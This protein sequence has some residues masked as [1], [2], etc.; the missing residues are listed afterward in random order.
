M[1]TVKRTRL[2]RTTSQPGTLIADQSVDLYARVPG[3]LSRIAVDI[4]SHV[5]RGDVLAELYD[6]ELDTL[7]EKARAEV[8]RARAHVEQAKAAVL[9]AQATTSLEQAKVEAA[10]AAAKDTEARAQSQ[11]KRLDRVRELNKA[12]AVEERVADA[13]ADEHA[14]S[15]TSSI[16]A[17]SELQ[18][19]RAAE[20]ET[21]AKN[22]MAKAD[23]LAAR[24]EL[25]V[26]EAGIRNADVIASYRKIESPFGGVVTR[27]NY[28]LG[29]WVRSPNLGAAQP[30]VTIVQTKTMRLV[31][32]VPERDVPYLDEGDA[33]KVWFDAVGA[34][35][36]Y[37]GK[38]SRTA[39]ALD[40][41]D[42]QSPRRDRSVQR[43]RPPAARIDGE[44]HDQPGDQ[45]KC[46]HDPEL[47]AR[48][49]KSGR[50]GGLLR[51][52]GRACSPSPNQGRQGQ[53]RTCRGSRR[54]DGW[55]VL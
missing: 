41:R 54:A 4:G 19:A 7:T 32:N 46:S 12:G 14:A 24:S 15:T 39:Y 36:L 18:V 6:P 30:I 21:Q 49:E 47:R 5:H 28:H 11:K 23:V 10:S 34:G 13:I 29:E 3:H 27:R 33:V 35:T 52:R 17:R 44:G 53:R 25:R 22:E 26:A 48:R 20:L 8:D 55:G 38:I 16:A 50:R 2:E 9:V 51:R 1:A 40:P 37:E 42:R 43:K 31:V 45:G